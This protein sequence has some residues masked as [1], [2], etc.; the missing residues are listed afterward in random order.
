MLTGG[1]LGGLSLIEISFVPTAKLLDPFFNSVVF[2]S[3]FESLTDIK[4]HTLTGGATISTAEKYF[5]NSSLLCNGS[6]LSYLGVADPNRDFSVNSNQSFTFDTFINFVSLGSTNYFHPFIEIGNPLS[7]GFRV[8][9]FNAVSPS[10]ELIIGNNPYYINWS[11]SI[12]TWYYFSVERYINTIY[13]KTNGIQIGSN[14]IDSANITSAAEN[15]IGASILNSSQ[16][17]ICYF[18]DM[19]FTKEYRNISQIPLTEF[20]NN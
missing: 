14:I 6:T 3:H 2:G 17:A 5:G 4:G 9:Y 13:L 20:S 1:K 19:R 18:D 8:G 7:T 16:R 10:I 11:P 15:S 12:N